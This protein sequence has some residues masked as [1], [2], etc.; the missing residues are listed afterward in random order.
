MIASHLT[1]R[2]DVTLSVVLLVYA[3]RTALPLGTSRVYVDEYVRLVFASLV[4]L[5]AVLLLVVSRETRRMKVLLAV[6]ATYL[7]VTLLALVADWTRFAS[8]ASS[9][10]LAILALM[11]WTSAKVERRPG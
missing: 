1:R 3:V 8:A 11:L 6:S 4:A 10:G 2:A 5:P 9:L 7:Y